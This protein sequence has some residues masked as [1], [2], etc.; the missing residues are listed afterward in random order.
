MRCLTFGTQLLT[1]TLFTDDWSNAGQG[2]QGQTSELCLQGWSCTR[3]VVVLRRRLREKDLG[4]LQKKKG[5]MSQ[6]VFGFIEDSVD[7]LYE[8]SVLVTTL[9]ESIMTIAQ[10]YRD[11]ADS[12]N[13]FDEL[14]NQWGWAG[15]MT[16]DLKRCRLMTK[17]IGL[18]YNWWSI[19]VRFGK[20]ASHQEAITSRPLMLNAIGRKTVHGG[21]KRLTI[22]SCHRDAGKIA[23]L[24]SCIHRF[25]GALMSDARQLTSKQRWALILQAAFRA[26]I[27]K[28][29]HPPPSPALVAQ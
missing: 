7:Q 26:F 17:M 16:Q 12:E 15:Y 23:K 1:L 27:G 6:Q 19:F 2:W 14:K 13:A 29:H 3:R 5:S 18:V 21:Q 8:Y 24:L 9:D 25:L 11:R 22:T 20:P 4:I 10:H 28:N